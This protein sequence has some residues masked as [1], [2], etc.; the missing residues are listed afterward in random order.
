MNKSTIAAL[1]VFAGL[2]AG[3][4][5]T[6]RQPA[7]RG[8]T[9][10]SFADVEPDRV[11]RVVVE[12][13]D[14]VELKKDD[15]AWKV[16]GKLADKDAVERLLAAV[17]K[18]D[19]SDLASRN[20]EHYAEFEVGAE[21]GAHVQVFAGA[22][23]VAEFV[24]GKSGRGGSYVLAD[25]AVYLVPGVYRGT[26][27][28]SRSAWLDRKLFAE[29]IDGVEKVEVALAGETPYVLTKQDGGWA[30][31]DSSLLPAGQRFDAKA[32]E[33]LVRSLVSAQATDFLDEDPGSEQ[34][35]LGEG[36]DQLVF[37][38]GGG[39]SRTLEIG[40]DK[41]SSGVYAKASTRG[42]VA[43][44][45]SYTA[46]GLRKKVADLR[47]LRLMSFEPSEVKRVEI[48]GADK[49]LVL[50]REAG[51][52]KVA[53]SSEKLGDDFAV[54]PQLVTRRIAMVADLKASEDAD[55]EVEVKD[56]KARVALTL[57]D[58]RVVTLAFGD[59]TKTEENEVVLARGN[60][61]DRLYYVTKASR[62]GVLRG[63]ESFKKSAQPGGFAGIDPEALKN[64]PPDVQDAI[65]KQMAQEQQKQKLFE[66]LEKQQAQKGGE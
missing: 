19:S 32:A 1:L 64:L 9:R 37:H 21:K 3:A 57:S 60:A 58:D 17:E 18:I 63:A 23:P 52:W 24:I 22:A 55:G 61:D 43:T 30:L 31:A 56:P 14:K 38:L 4:Y 33:S 66:T 49:R 44:L 25:G 20:E 48:D 50:E 36:A 40:K 53:E 62:D 12:E 10:I 47:D 15:G 45:S 65:R 41:D 11:T 39:E 35:G 26:F 54:D 59:E 13:S 51:D 7:E 29:S 42:D 34:T 27:A 2:A 8:V 5:V 6:F 28:R 16:E 46:R